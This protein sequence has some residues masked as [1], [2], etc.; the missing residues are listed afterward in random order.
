MQKKIY[1]RDLLIGKGPSTSS[2]RGYKE[3]GPWQG[4]TCRKAEQAFLVVTQAGI[5]DSAAS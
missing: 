5:F 1:E 2:L 3:R 4:C